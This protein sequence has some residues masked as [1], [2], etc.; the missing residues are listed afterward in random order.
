MRLQAQTT[1]QRP[2][3]YH[4]GVPPQMDEIAAR[5]DKLQAETD[6]IRTRMA[7]AA[8]NDE[9]RE[10]RDALRLRSLEAS[11]LQEELLAEAQVMANRHEAWNQKI[12]ESD[13]TRDRTL[14]FVGSVAR[15]SVLAAIDKLHMFHRL[16]PEGPITITFNS[17]G[18]SVIDGMALFD[19]IRF[20]RG[21]GHHVTII[22]LGYA[23]SMAGILLQAA[24][25]RVMAK[26]SWLLIHE[27]AFGAG[28]KIGEVE[29]MYEFGKRLKEQAANIFIERS[30][31]K[32]SREVLDKN[33]TR[34]DWWLSADEALELGLIDEIR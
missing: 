3:D 8:K 12:R 26:G 4:Q 21:Q 7:R 29:D 30:G 2:T 10:V 24:D 11:T 19:Y 6:E 33:W 22:G 15:D 14:N 25:L 9:L 34:K 27:V 5:V 20:L 28:G 23:A 31:G 32:L 17:P 16:D 18:G 1:N 13:W